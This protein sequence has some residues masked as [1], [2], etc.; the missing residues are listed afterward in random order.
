MEKHEMVLIV[1]SSFCRPYIN[2]IVCETANG[3]GSSFICCTEEWCCTD[4]REGRLLDS[5]MMMNRN[6]VRG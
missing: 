4:C 1:F 2:L 5:K 6:R 3:Q